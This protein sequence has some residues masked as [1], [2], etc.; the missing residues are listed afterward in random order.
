MEEK[1]IAGGIDGQIGRRGCGWSSGKH[2]MHID[3]P[4]P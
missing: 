4:R 3:S 1:Y 2:E